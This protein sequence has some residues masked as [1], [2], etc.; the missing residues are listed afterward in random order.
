MKK[1]PPLVSGGGFLVL[2]LLLY[3]P[4]SISPSYVSNLSKFACLAL[5]A[6][7]LLNGCKGKDGDPGP[8]GA[9]GATGATGTAGTAGTSG[10]NLTGTLFGFV[11]P[12]DEYGNLLTKSGV[13]VTLEGVTPAATA[14]TN[15]D[16]RYEFTNLR[17][18]TYNLSFSRTGLATVRRLGVAHV[19]GDQ[20]TFLGTN[21]I[22]A[23]STTTLGNLSVS[24]QSA[25][26]VTLN[27]PYTNP[28]TPSGLFTRLAIYASSSPGVTAANGSLLT[29]YS[30]SSSPLIAGFTK[31]TFN[32]A[33][34]A[35]GTAVYMVVYGAPA[36][37]TTFTDP[38]T[39]RLTY[40]GLT[41]V[42]SNQV[43]FIV[44]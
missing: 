13:T 18:G 1:K 32:S 30:V 2:A 26:S 24:G 17:N 7:L 8:A 6:A 35:S 43:A 41:A 16:G 22:S 29:I 34:F 28:G 31:A 37:L 19:G 39:G 21:S 11:A 5:S 44:P 33:G 14:T 40:N 10:Q 3:F 9:A 25:T 27:I 42:S 23:P 38:L 12:S 4:P 15:A 36:V 20:P